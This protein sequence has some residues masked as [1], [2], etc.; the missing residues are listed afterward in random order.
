LRQLIDVDDHDRITDVHRLVGDGCP[1]D[2]RILDHDT[3]TVDR[4]DDAG[5]ADD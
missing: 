2:D 3:R 5:R 1:D 4:I